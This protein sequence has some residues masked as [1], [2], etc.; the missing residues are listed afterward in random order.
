[1][2]EQPRK[3]IILAHLKTLP[4]K[5][6]ISYVPDGAWVIFLPRQRS[7]LASVCLKGSPPDLYGKRSPGQKRMD[8]SLEF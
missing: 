8:S 2:K 3:K 6:K 1:M 7:C 5:K 4:S